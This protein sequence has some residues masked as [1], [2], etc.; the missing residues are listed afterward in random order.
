MSKDEQSDGALRRREHYLMLGKRWGD[1]GEKNIEKWGNQRPKG[2]LL[3]MAEE[4]AEIA[5]ELLEDNGLPPN[6]YQDREN[7]I[8][9]DIRTT[10]YVAREFLEEQ[11]EDENGDPLPLSERPELSGVADVKAAREETEDLAPLLFQMY[12]AL[13]DYDVNTDAD[14]SEGG[15]LDE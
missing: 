13:N 2:L 8:L 5:D 12:W 4:M 1:R 6:A 3:A 14:R 10:G 15:D 9:N 11:C 7:S